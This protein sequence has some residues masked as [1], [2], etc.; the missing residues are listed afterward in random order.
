MRHV[1]LT[2]I[3]HP[4][5]R[6][7]TKECAVTNGKYNGQR[8]LSFDGIPITNADDTPKMYFD[9]SGVECE[10]VTAD[11]RYVKECS[12]PPSDLVVAEEDK[13]VKRYE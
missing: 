1:I 6:W 9:L 5:L 12:C 3:N 13:L 8:N 11:G 4:E 7:S 2:C 10:M